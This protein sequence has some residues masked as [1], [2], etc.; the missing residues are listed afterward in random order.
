M[1][2]L[3]LPIGLLAT[4]TFLAACGGP[5]GTNTGGGS[6]ES[7]E[8]NQ[9]TAAEYQE[10][11]V[12][13][14][15]FQLAMLQEPM[16]IQTASVT[17]LSGAQVPRPLVN[18]LSTSGISAQQTDDCVVES[19]NTTDADGDS[20]PVNATYTYDCSSAP[21][22]SYQYS[23]T[24]SA[25]LADKNDNDSNSGYSMKM[26]ALEYQFG[27]GSDS[28]TLTFDLDF[29]LT[30]SGATYDAVFDFGFSAT[31]PD[32]SFTI[33]FDFD[34]T[35]LAD[36]QAD[37]FASGNLSFTGN[38]NLN[39]DGDN[40]SLSVATSPSLSVDRTCATGYASGAAKY[41]DN[42]G[43]DVSVNY[44]CDTASATY[45]GSPIAAN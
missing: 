24:G 4:M 28:A 26:T 22:D 45:N 41:S 32:G 18:T 2:K 30:I 15:E 13:G 5:G 27:Q 29:D 14:S 43:N 33:G 3:L 37:P 7:Q 1:K 23:L 11:A 38:L 35:Y 20:V 21:E 6:G 25:S 17:T 9:E 16:Q 36:N 10:L 42:A 19:G 44:A 8:L 39:D 40:Y 31:G 12:Q 34:Q